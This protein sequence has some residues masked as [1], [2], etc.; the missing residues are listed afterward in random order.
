MISP[1]QLLNQPPTDA[2]DTDTSVEISEATKTSQVSEE[3]TE[4]TPAPAPAAVPTATTNKKADPTSDPEPTPSPVDEEFEKEVEMLKQI[5]MPVNG[6]D[7]AQLEQDI[8][9]ML[10]EIKDFSWKEP[11]YAPLPTLDPER[12]PTDF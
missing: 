5:L 1:L 9:R 10:E 4:D 6:G 11:A 2:S 3:L 8:R 7:E 12:I